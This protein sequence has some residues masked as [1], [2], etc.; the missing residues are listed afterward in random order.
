MKRRDF[1]IL[2]GGAMA[3]APV[4]AAAQ[5]PSRIGA[6]AVRFAG[7]AATDDDVIARNY[8]PGD[9]V[10]AI[11]VAAPSTVMV[12]EEFTVGVRVLIPPYT[13][14]LD[15]FAVHYP[16]VSSSTSLS[17]RGISY[18]DNVPP[19]WQGTL[20][21]ES[22][23]PFQG[24]RRISFDDGHGPYPHDH[25]PI[26]RIGPF[27]FDCPG[28]HYFVVTDP[29][30][31][32]CQLSSPVEVSAQPLD[33]RLFWGDIHGHTILTDGIR[34][35]EEYYYFA[36]DE[37]FLDICALSDHTEC[38]LT[39]RQWEYLTAVTNDFNDSGRF[40]T[41]VA[42]EWTNHELG[43][44]NLYH[45][46]NG[47]PFIKAT[48]PAFSELSPLYDFARK[49]G[50]IVVPHH[51]ANTAIGVDWSL[52]HDPMVE[53]LVEV[54]SCWGNSERSAREGNHRPIH[55]GMLG[56]EKPGRHV[57]DALRAGRRFGIIASGDIHDGRPGDCIS[58]RQAEPDIYRYTQ[59]GGLMG[60]WCRSLDRRHVFDALWNR[61]VYGTTGPRILLRFAIDGHPMGSE[62]TL[63]QGAIAQIQ[64]ASDVPITRIDLVKDGDDF[65]SERTNKRDVR[66][67]MEI[68]PDDGA[69]SY[70]VRVTRE[71]GETAWS[72]PIWVRRA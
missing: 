16:A 63:R 48:D 52:G 12:G 22:E 33:E 67:Q 35:P 40:V 42:Q 65:R 37:A 50:A 20:E 43:H 23:A 66:C 5:I 49:H 41:L 59:P 14:P 72:S 36:R 21:I 60:V 9:S 28:T 51:S 10:T 17:P 58:Y 53:R 44:R 3:G 25:R 7:D 29:A 26:R 6:P 18:M 57:V 69:A 31:G 46:G 24:P 34:S 56:G 8:T 61:R 2:S 27:A 64:T 30:S 15:V 19:Q 55:E 13:A 62:A 47:A 1:L 4:L 54:Y 38:Y 71:D 11:S 39:D 68:D 70:Y 45:P 32:V